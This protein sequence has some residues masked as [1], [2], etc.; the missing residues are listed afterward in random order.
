VAQLL[1]GKAV[2]KQVRAEVARGV[3]QF[4]EQHGRAPGLHV[5]IAGEDPASLL[6]TRNK[7]KA[8]LEIGMAGKLHT[9]PA[10]VT[11]AELL[12]LVRQLNDDPDVDGILVQ[13][14][15]P[16]GIRSEAVLETIDP[17]KDVDGFHAVNVGALWSGQHGLVPCT[18]RGCMRLLAEA[19]VKLAGARAVVVGRS[20]IVGKPMAAL[21]LAEHA[22]VTVA[23]SR[24]ADLAARCRE[25]DV[26]IAAVGRARLLGADAIKPGAVVIDVGQNRDEQG[27]LCGDVDYQAAL[28][29]ASAITPVPGGVGPM[30]IAMLLDNTLIAARARVATKR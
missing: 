16:R 2:A 14:P 19:G 28:A 27:K 15:L 1:D 21:L 3:Q 5:V 6:Y 29:V 12:R 23:H 9:L 18:P 11:E 10:S 26:L 17:N 4:K 20:N 8:A 24:T 25:A 13:M 7:E 30:T 22:T